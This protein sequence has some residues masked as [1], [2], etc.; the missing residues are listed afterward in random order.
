MP[1]YNPDSYPKPSVPKGTLSEKHTITSKIYDGMK[2]DFW[3]YASPGVDPNV[4]SPLM[5]WQDGQ[6][7]IAGD[8]SA[9]ALVYGD[10]EP[11][12]AE[13]DSTDGACADRARDF[14]PMAKPCAP[15]NTIP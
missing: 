4:P 12:G 9:L 15:L 14:R 10:R 13:A 1:G 2:A 8:L 5:V 7:L 11:S 3:W 6:G